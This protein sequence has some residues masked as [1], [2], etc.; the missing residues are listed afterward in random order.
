MIYIS[1]DSEAY[2]ESTGI[3]GFKIGERVMAPR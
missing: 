3:S 2:K 1:L